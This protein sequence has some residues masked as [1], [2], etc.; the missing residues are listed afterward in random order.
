MPIGIELKGRE[1]YQYV[2]LKALI[3]YPESNFPISY[4]G[5]KI[6]HTLAYKSR[7]IPVLWTAGDLEGHW[8]SV[9]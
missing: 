8:S 2:V 6:A 4:R 5:L 3:R 7:L 9:I 1:H